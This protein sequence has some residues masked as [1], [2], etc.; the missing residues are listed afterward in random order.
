MP[1][2]PFRSPNPGCERTFDQTISPVLRLEAFILEFLEAHHD[3]RED[4]NLHFVSV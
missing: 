2:V 4:R 3:L 1:F